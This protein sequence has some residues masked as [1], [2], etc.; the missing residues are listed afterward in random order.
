MVS[1]ESSES[2][3]EKVATGPLKKRAKP[4]VAAAAND[5]DSSEFE[6]EFDDDLFQ[7]EE[8]RKW[9]MTRSELEVIR[10]CYLF[11]LCRVAW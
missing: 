6:D 1:Q 2:E 9:M 4:V 11:F 7:G 10:K 8:D 3:D 5:S